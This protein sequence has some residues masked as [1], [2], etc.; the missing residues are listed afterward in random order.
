MSQAEIVELLLRGGAAGLNLLIA[1]AFVRLAARSEAARFGALFSVAV[2]VYAL[3][4]SPALVEAFAPVM[5][6]IELFSHFLPVFFWWFALALFCDAFRWTPWRLVPFGVIAVLAAAAAAPLPD[7]LDAAVFI[8][9]RVVILA[10]MAH[11]LVIA[12]R[13]WRDDLVEPRR[14]F[15]LFVSTAIALVVGVTAGIEIWDRFRP[16]PDFLHLLQAATVFAVSLCV[17]GWSLA[18]R[19]QFFPLL[20]AG[21]TA[22]SRP[23]HHVAVED[24]ALLERLDA[25]ME[26]GG[27]AEPGLTVRGLAERLNTQEHRLR[28]VINQGLGYRNFSAFLNRY[29]VDAA[30]RALADPGQ[31][32]KQILQIALDLGYGSIAPFN[33]AFRD[34]T[35]ETPTGFRRAALE[36]A[37]RAAPHGAPAGAH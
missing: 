4:S 29:R 19:R 24:G 16:K 34:A 33:R 2:A 5:A 27:Y 20:P 26:A 36:S 22:A 9:W 35:G 23:A 6:G 18:A 12:M 15:R 11:V 3:C 28:S 25:F 21:A 8:L 17:A 30:K 31:A 14:R 7:I 1:A 13:D 10:L 37:A 32:R